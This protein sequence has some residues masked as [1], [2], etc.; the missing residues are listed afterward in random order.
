MVL[1]KLEQPR[2][3]ITIISF[4]LVGL[5]MEIFKTSGSIQSW[6]YPGDAFFHAANVPL[7]SG[8]MYAPV[9]SYIAPAWRVFDL[10]FTH[11]PRRLYTIFLALA[12]Y[13]NFFT[14]H[15]TY[16]IRYL[17]F[18]AVLVLYGRTWVYCTLHKTRRRMPLYYGLFT[19]SRCSSSRVR[20]I[21]TF[22]IKMV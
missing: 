14:H 19:A 22:F 16:D 8:F 9:G 5:G 7:F 1:T 4:H 2:E 18:A 12:I 17:L 6:T 15:Y 13:Q 21:T 10:S 11:Y 20:I 3:I